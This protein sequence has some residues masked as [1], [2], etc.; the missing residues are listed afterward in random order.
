[1]IDQNQGTAKIFESQAWHLLCNT[2][3]PLHSCQ[4]YLLNL[5]LYPHFLPCHQPVGPPICWRQLH[6]SILSLQAWRESEQRHVT[7]RTHAS[8]EAA[9]MDL[10]NF[11]YSYTLSTTTPTAL[12]DVLMAADKFEV[13]SRMRHCSRMLRNLPMTCESA[14]LYLD[15]PSSVLMAEAVQPLT[16]AAKRFLAARY[17]DVTKFQ[18]EVLNLLLAGI[19]VV[20]SSD[21]LQVA[22]EDAVYDF[23]LK[24]ARIHYPKLEDR[25]EILGSRLGCLIRFP[26]MTCRKLNEVL[27]CN[28]FD[29]ELASK[30]ASY[31]QRSLA[32][33]KA[34]SSYCRFV[35]RAYKY[36]PVKVVEFE[37]PRQQC[38]G[39]LV[40]SRQPVKDYIDSAVRHVLLR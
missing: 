29:T 31:R 14:L 11:M 21:D 40:S 36:R 8:E 26:Y 4:S 6:L 2:Q 5:H 23:V 15:L 7:L 1:M 20:L 9:Q 18:E 10:L 34:N 30:V 17:K 24:W 33:E 27:T 37:L 35:E 19:E 32:A 39:Y 13:A 3:Q 38:V 25:R 22:S 12:L 28:D 16:D